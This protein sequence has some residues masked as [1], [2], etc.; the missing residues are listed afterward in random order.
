LI[1]LPCLILFVCKYPSMFLSSGVGF[2]TITD[3][4][5][6]AIIGEWFEVKS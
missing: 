3:V 1:D 6:V 5:N 4:L 2:V